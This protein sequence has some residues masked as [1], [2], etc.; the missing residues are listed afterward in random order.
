L[1]YWMKSQYSTFDRRRRPGGFFQRPQGGGAAPGSDRTLADRALFD[2]PWS[3]LP[4]NQRAEAAPEGA[5][6][7]RRLSSA[8]TTLGRNTTDLGKSAYYLIVNG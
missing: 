1:E 5:F 8:G 6:P 7:Q 4:R 3:T 2:L